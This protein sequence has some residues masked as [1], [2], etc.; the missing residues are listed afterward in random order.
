MALQYSPSPE[1]G[2]SCP[3]FK[4][5]SVDGEIFALDD[6]SGASVFVVFFICN[7]CPYVKAVEDRLIEIGKAYGAKEV[8][9]AA[10]CSNDPKDYPEDAPT[11]LLKRWKQKS[12]PFPYL[13]DDTQ[14]V[15]RKFGA[16]CTPDIFVFDRDRKLRYRGRLDDSWKDV[17]RVEKR[18]LKQAIDTLLRGELP[19]VEQVPTM[20][21]SIKWKNA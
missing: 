18:E 8:A 19:P 6:F 4:L 20:G 5:H 17:K 14:K 13:L 15:A 3:E 12:Y 9:F 21:C 16:V 7:H 1:L 11:E 10:I 2:K